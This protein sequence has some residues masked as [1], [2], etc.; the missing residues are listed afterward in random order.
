MRRCVV[1][2]PKRTPTYLYFGCG[3]I[4]KERSDAEIYFARHRID[5]S[6]WS[7]RL[8]PGRARRRQVHAVGVLSPVA[9]SS[10]TWL[11]SNGRP[12]SGRPDQRLKTF[13]E[14]AVLT[15]RIILRASYLSIELEL[16]RSKTS[17]QAPVRVC[18]TSP[19]R[20]SVQPKASRLSNP[21]TRYGGVLTK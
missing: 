20:R 9:S 4:R 2:A 15:A 11:W 19:S 16:A 18:R 12:I 1:I 3:L 10:L 6:E 14:P 5:D 21:L 17:V 13:T 7:W 8:R